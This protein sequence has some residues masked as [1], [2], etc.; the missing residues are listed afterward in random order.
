MKTVGLGLDE[1][2]QSEVMTV[3]REETAPLGSAITPRADP[4]INRRDPGRLVV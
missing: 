3:I 1:F 2:E 4:D